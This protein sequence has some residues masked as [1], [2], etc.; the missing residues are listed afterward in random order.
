M[1]RTAVIGLLVII[2]GALSYF[3]ILGGKSKDSA[4]PVRLFAV[5]QGNFVASVLAEGKTVARKKEQLASPIAG[6]V[7]DGGFAVGQLVPESSVVAVVGLLETDLMK[8]RQEFEFAKIDLEVLSEQLD[9]SEELFRAKAVSERELKEL[10]IR[11]YKQEKFVQ[12]LREELREKQILTTF[13]GT[14][15]EKSFREGDRISAGFVLCTVVDPKSYAVEINVPQ[16]LIGKVTL[17]QLVQYSSE[18]FVAQ[19]WGTVLEM[20]RVADR[21]NNPGQYGGPQ[22]A[23]PEFRVTAS[24]N[25]PDPDNLLLGSHVD[26]RFIIAEKESV[27]FVPLEAV[28]YRYDTTAVFVASQGIAKMRRVTLGLINDRFAEVVK[29]LGLGDSV[30][31]HGNLDLEDGI[32]IKWMNREANDQEQQPRGRPVLFGQ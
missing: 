14:L 32:A 3:Y 30:V 31:T 8:K 2:T 11:K 13:G 22:N 20:A 28:L 18:T 16:H 23:E 26:G 24:I 9:Q 12:N 25:K 15:V 17:G 19:L 10:R 21:P 27:L 7:H 1:I 29:G 4:V 6:I 5:E